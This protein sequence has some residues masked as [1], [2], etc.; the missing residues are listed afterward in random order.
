MEKRNVKDLSVYRKRFEDDASSFNEFQAMDFVKELKNQGLN[1]EAIEVGKTFMQAAPA[2]TKYINHYAYALYN[3]FI[4]IDEEQIAAKENLFFS[5]VDEIV[6]LCAQEN[7]SPLEVTINKA[8]KYVLNQNPVDWAKLN[9]LLDKL[10]PL[11]LDDKPFV[12]NEGKE[13]ESK[14]EKWYRLKVRATY[15]L[16]DYRACVEACNVALNTRLKWHYS[17]L[18]WIKYYRACSLVELER[19]NEAQNEF[20]ALKGRFNKVNFDVI[21]QLYLNTDQKNEAY[22]SLIYE[23]F[24]SGYDLENMNIYNHILEMAKDKNVENIIVLTAALINKLNTENGKEATIDVD[25]SKYDNADSSKVYDSLYN[26]LMDNLELF[27]E[28]QESKVVY[29]NEDKEYGSLYVH[30]SD[31]LFFRQADYIYDEEVQK[32][33]VVEFSVMKTFDTK[34]QQPTSKAVLLKTLYEDINY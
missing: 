12:N 7:Y 6:E 15:E 31:N 5:I 14:K 24:V 8:M 34:K 11:T 10:N 27:I 22:T 20:L 9:D 18:N 4:K 23:F 29:Y 13:F 17:N 3:K 25:I 2:L 26:Q 1:D 19:Y 28:R 16:K 21:Y 30:D 32:R 33:D